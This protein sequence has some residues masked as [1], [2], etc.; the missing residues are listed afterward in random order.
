MSGGSYNYLCH[1][2]TPADVARYAGIDSLEDMARDLPDGHPVTAWTRELLATLNAPIP[3]AVSDVWQAREWVTSGDRTQE[4]LD[5][6]LD[7]TKR[8]GMG[9]RLGDNPELE[10]MNV[11][12]RDSEIPDSMFDS[13]LASA[14]AH[15]AGSGVGDY[16][17]MLWDDE[18]NLVDTGVILVRPE[19]EGTTY[20]LTAP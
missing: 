1:R 2:E 11:T 19:P 18:G 10:A 9:A 7:K 4:D 14:L 13:T 6:A 15:L 8:W 3:Q 20:R 5:E 12:V 16:E 17:T